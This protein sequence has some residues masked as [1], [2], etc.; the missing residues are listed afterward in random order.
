MNTTNIGTLRAF[1]S[2]VNRKYLNR[3][4]YNY[5]LKRWDLDKVDLDLENEKIKNKLSTLPKS[6]REAI[7]EFLIIRS[8]L[9]EIEKTKNDGNVEEEIS[10]N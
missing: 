6:R 3:E 4:V 2:V 7:P 5:L 9:N 10:F 8:I 1:Y